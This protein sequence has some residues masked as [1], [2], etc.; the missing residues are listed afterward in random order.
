[1]MN[2]IEREKRLHVQWTTRVDDWKK[3]HTELSVQKFKDFMESSAITN[4]DG[5]RTVLDQ[6]K[7]DQESLNERRI[8]LINSLRYFITLKYFN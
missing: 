3:L 5:A 6:M 2:D 8:E 1:M 4:P 7:I